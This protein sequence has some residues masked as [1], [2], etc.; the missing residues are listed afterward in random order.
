MPFT[1]SRK[2]LETELKNIL[3]TGVSGNP[4][5]YLSWVCMEVKKKFKEDADVSLEDVSSILEELKSQNQIGPNKF[6]PREF[7]VHATTSFKKKLQASDMFQC[8]GRMDFNPIQYVRS[9]L[10]YYLLENKVSEEEALDL[11]IAIVEAV[12]NSVKYGDGN[13]IEVEYSFD[14]NRLFKVQ[15]TNTVKEFNLEDD[16]ERGKFSST[17]TLM[18]GMMVM[19]KLFDSIDLEIIDDK[20]IAKFLAQKQFGK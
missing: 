10:E 1:F 13:I 11:G 20:K 2:E 15:V 7:Q 5:D 4:K 9:R 16:I 17:A 6:D 8:L 3:A 14:K 12:E 19:Q 18:R